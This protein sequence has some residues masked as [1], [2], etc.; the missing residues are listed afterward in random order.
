MKKLSL[1]T[2][3]IL[4][5]GLLST[6]CNEKMV[7]ESKTMITGTIDNA[8]GQVVYIQKLNGDT[9]KDSTVIAPDGSFALVMDNPPMD[10]YRFFTEDMKEPVLLAIDSTQ[11]DIK[12]TGD[13]TDLIATYDII[14]SADSR[15][16]QDL[17]DKKTAYR[18][19][20]DSIKNIQ[21]QLPADMDATVKKAI[22]QQDE[23]LK[24]TFDAEM[25]SWAV[26]NSKSIS[27]LVIIS[28]VDLLQA[29]P[30]YKKIRNDLHAVSPG[31]P[32]LATMDQNIVNLEKAAKKQKGQGHLSPG[33]QAPEISQASPEGETIS[34]SSLKGK[35]VLIDFWAS[36]CGP[37]RRENPNVKR[38]YDKYAGKDFEILSV[39]LDNSPDRWKQAIAQDGMNWLHVSDLK[40]W[41][42]A[43]AADYGVRSIPFTVLV[44]PDGNIV[45]TK[46]RGAGLQQKLEELFG[47]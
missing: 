21:S 13:A 10:F 36:W 12:L 2:I 35:Y 7:D 23:K 40:K 22:M 39:S 28:E 38:L 33:A 6:S 46:L 8:N 34:L 31:S 15:L 32:Y 29:I 44:D 41:D 30:E 27:S 37:C 18:Q 9:K 42:S 43:A 19:D 17:R 5:L 26:A 45:A 4:T 1:L 14:G 11:R 16:L 47:A 24:Q 25:R 20:L 3:A